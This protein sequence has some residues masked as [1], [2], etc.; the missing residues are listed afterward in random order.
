MR[1]STHVHGREKRKK[2]DEGPREGEDFIK[3]WMSSTMEQG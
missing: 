3:E 2:R 1:R